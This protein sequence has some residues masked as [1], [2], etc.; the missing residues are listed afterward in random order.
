MKEK[1]KTER[2]RMLCIAAAAGVF[3]LSAC[4]GLWFSGILSFGKTG[5]IHT[6]K[7]ENEKEIARVWEIVFKGMKLTV[8]EKGMACVHESGCLNI[9]R[10][11][12]YLIQ[13]DIEDDILENMWARMD[14]KK[15]TLTESGYRIDK[16]PEW[17]SGKERSYVRYVISMANE[18]G[19]D[20]E[21]SYF[22]VMLLP[23]DAGR[24]FLAVIRF[25]GLDV[26]H[27]EAG[28][29]D[30][31]YEE[32]AEAVL[33]ILKQAAPT[34]EKDDETGTFWMEDENLDPDG[35]YISA[36]SLSDPDGGV[37]L[38]YGL[39][40]GSQLIS[41]DISGKTYLDTE[42]R[43]YIHT[44]VIHY[45]WKT[46]NETAEKLAAGELSRIHKQGEVRVGNRLF[47]YYSYSVLEY[48]KEKSKT[49]YYF[50]A[51]CDLENGD[52]YSIYGNAD[53]CPKTLDAAYYL[54]VMNLVEA[55]DVD[56][57]A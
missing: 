24:H 28:M 16:E 44:S 21:R 2:G 15:K 53:D 43:I 57:P 31:I 13:I 27:L 48:G 4:M 41:D 46:A 25:D 26:E 49:H 34:E 37:I 55:N 30:R 9:R 52:I 23:A 47:Y 33:D 54:D 35:A 19:S 17:N 6:E 36:D 20:F 39:P 1:G 40:E 14:N 7:S 11:E 42:N 5:E 8:P 50:R 22:E 32:A 10:Q 12:E 45:T 3:L 56:E 29:R 18:R 38:S 51:F